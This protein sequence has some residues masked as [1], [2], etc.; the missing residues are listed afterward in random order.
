ALD[1]WETDADV[2]YAFD[3]PGVPE[4]KISI[5]FEDGT[6][7]VS[8]RRDQVSEVSK[9]RF[10]RFERRHGAFARTIGLPAGVTEDSISASF[11]DGALEIHV[12]KP[13]APKPRR[14][15]IGGDAKEAIEGQATKA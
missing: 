2:V 15:E 9:D 10:Y 1:A 12:A 3:L 6:L 13:Q 14:I 8:G 4:D 7:T 11:K 5:E